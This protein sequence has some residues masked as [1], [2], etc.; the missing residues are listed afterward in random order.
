MEGWRDG[1]R[2]TKKDYNL[3]K[4]LSSHPT[5]SVFLMHTQIAGRFLHMVGRC[6]HHYLCSCF[7]SIF[8]RRLGIESRTCLEG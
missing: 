4:Y 2:G 6:G 8:F 7:D 3:F 1:G 5:E